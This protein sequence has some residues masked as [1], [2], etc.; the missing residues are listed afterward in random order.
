MRMEHG[1]FGFAKNVSEPLEL[2]PP[3]ENPTL[4]F[5]KTSPSS[6]PAWAAIAK[7]LSTVLIA[8]SCDS[9]SL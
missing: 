2:S 7:A 8:H 5:Q 4:G 6:T 9:K 1:R 3:A